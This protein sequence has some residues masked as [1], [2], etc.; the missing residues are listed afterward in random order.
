MHSCILS[1]RYDPDNES[2]SAVEA[3]KSND[4]IQSGD[5]DAGPLDGPHT[6]QSLV[7]M[8]KELRHDRD[9]LHGAYEQVN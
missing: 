1:H 9:C 2:S 7:Q 4:S 5:G 6:E 8:V 3:K